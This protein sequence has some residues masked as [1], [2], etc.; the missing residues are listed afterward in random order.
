MG[1]GAIVLKKVVPEAWLR[2]AEADGTSG[3]PQVSPD[4]LGRRE[5][6]TPFGLGLIS[7]VPGR[8]KAESQ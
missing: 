4:V 3:V 7:L 5:G 2:Q 6:G 1:L 8:D